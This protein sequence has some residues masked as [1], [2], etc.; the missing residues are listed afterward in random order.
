[1]GG[2]VLVGVAVPVGPVGAPRLGLVDGRR[3]TRTGCGR[4]SSTP[5][6]HCRGATAAVPVARCEAMSEL[7]PT[8]SR[9]RAAG[10]RRDLPRRGR[11][12]AHRGAD[13][14]RPGAARGR[15][16]PR[17]TRRCCGW[18]AGCCRC[19][20]CWRC[21]RR[22]GGATG[23]GC[24]S[25]RS[26]P[27]SAA[28]CCCRRLDAGGR[29]PRSGDQLGRAARPTSAACRCRGP[30]PFVDARPDRSA[31]L[32]PTARL[33]GRRSPSARGAPGLDAGRA[34]RRCAEVADHAAGPAR[35]ACSGAAWCTAT[36]TRRTCWSTRTRSR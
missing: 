34:R 14:R 26:C 21:A 22:P 10:Q 8:L 19:P 33:A 12:G 2:L 36:S 32:G 15:A 28:T 13:L 23:P 24:W 5:R 27:G 30:G 7:A 20:R 1:M 4:R 16:H 25:R 29:W 17:S 35:H 11:R 18:C 6:L 3:S 31:P 9:W